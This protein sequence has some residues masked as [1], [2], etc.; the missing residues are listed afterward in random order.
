MTTDEANTYSAV[1]DYL[2]K[3]K[4]E[5]HT[6]AASKE[7]DLLVS[8]FDKT[9]CW[10]NGLNQVFKLNSARIHLL[11]AASEI[12]NI[13]ALVPFHFYRQG[14]ISLRIIL[15]EVLAF[16]YFESHPKEFKTL[17]CDADFYISKTYIHD[18]HRKHSWS[19]IDN[20]KLDVWN[21]IE[22]QYKELSRIIHA[23]TPEQISLATS[24]QSFSHSKA[25]MNLLIDSARK[26]DEAVAIFLASIYQNEFNEFTHE[27]KKAIIKGWKREFIKEIGLRP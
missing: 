17:I 5:L 19:R 2:Y 26:N 15:D 20:V 12:V 1:I 4:S 14:I 21:G 18:F 13:L 25:Q 6:F 11:G 9:L 7:A 3:D 16:S 10:C 27:F 23:Q 8:S 24:F 22:S